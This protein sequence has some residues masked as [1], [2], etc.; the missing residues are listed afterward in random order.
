MNFYVLESAKE[1]ILLVIG[2]FFYSVDAKICLG[3]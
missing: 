3:G 2:K 1:T